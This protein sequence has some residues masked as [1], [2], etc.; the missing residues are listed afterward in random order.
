VELSPLDAER[1]A[2]ES[3]DEVQVRS[4]GHAVT[5]VVQIREGAKRGTATLTEG[6]K[7]GNANVLVDGAPV[8]VEVERT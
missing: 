6:T 5:A 8:L 3:G 2:V 4:N 1:L 7:E